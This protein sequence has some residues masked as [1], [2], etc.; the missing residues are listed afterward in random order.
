VNTL[1][2]GSLSQD[3]PG[4]HIFFSYSKQRWIFPKIALDPAKPT[5]GPHL[6]SF[7]LGVEDSVCEIDESVNQ[8]RHSAGEEVVALPND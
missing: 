8:H 7:A 6:A 2:P 5:A 3:G 1:E 4:L